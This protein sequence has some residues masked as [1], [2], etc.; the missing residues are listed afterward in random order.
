MYLCLTRGDG[1]ARKAMFKNSLKRFLPIGLFLAIVVPAFAHNVPYS[2]LD[3]AIEDQGLNGK[4]LIHTFDVASETLAFPDTFNDLAHWNSNLELLEKFLVERISLRSDRTALKLEVKKVE[5]VPA[6]QSIAISFSAK[7][8]S[9]A[10]LLQVH[11]RLFPTVPNHITYLTVRRGSGRAANPVPLDREHPD[12]Q[13]RSGLYQSRRNLFKDFVKEGVHHIFIGPDHIAFIIGLILLGG[14]LLRL[15]QIVT[16]FTLAH[17]ITLALAAMEVVKVPSKIVEP[18]I[19][20]SIIY[21][22]IENLF[23]KRRHRDDRALIA[24]IFG[25][26]H[27]FGF[28]SVLQEFGLPGSSLAMALFAFNFGVELGQFFILLLVVPVL[29]LFRTV[30]FSV[31]LHGFN[32][33]KPVTIG[34]VPLLSCLITFAGLY[35]LIVRLFLF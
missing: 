2:Y 31:R 14:S 17:S 4:L 32:Q 34:I 16:A 26:V 20:L 19:A 9:P 21:I 35:W 23:A 8:T 29:A 6:A 11:C 30:S 7:W 24:F 13:F 18:M 25:F 27:G 5:P 3:L 28:A 15:T 22:G 10:E 1:F 33:S 12:Y